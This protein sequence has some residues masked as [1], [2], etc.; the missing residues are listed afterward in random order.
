[1]QE[2]SLPFLAHQR[3]GSVLL[4]YG[5]TQS[6]D[7]HGFDVVGLPPGTRSPVGF[8][9]VEAS[10]DH[11]GSGYAA[12][13]GWVQVVTVVYGRDDSERLLDRPPNALGVEYPFLSAG[14]RP[15]LFDAP[16]ITEQDVRWTAQAFLTNSPDGVMS[17]QV[18]AVAGFRWGFDVAATG[19][20]SPY[21]PSPL[22]GAAWND[23]RSYLAA[24]QPRW[25]FLPAAY[26][27]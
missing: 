6:P 2:L 7:E 20:V 4:R 5:V 16:V 1:M 13:M 27:E 26:S 24:E 25:R 3:E 23:L 10:V 22:S 9:V 19:E 11:A 12:W 8:P 17:P 18:Q 21:V 14:V 15:T